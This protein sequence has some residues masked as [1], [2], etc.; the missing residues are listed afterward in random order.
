[1]AR[2]AVVSAIGLKDTFLDL[3]GEQALSPYYQRRVKNF[4]DGPDQVLGS[5]A[6]AC[7]RRPYKSAARSGMDRAWYQIV[8]Y[9]SAPKCSITAAPGIDRPG[10]AAAGLDQLAVRS[11]KHPRS[12]T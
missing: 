7:T 9:D 3:V 5:V 2:R 12:T 11:R 6:M 4:K 8:G 1:M 10:A